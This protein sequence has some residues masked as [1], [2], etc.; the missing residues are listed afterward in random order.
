MMCL[1]GSPSRAFFDAY[2]EIR[3]QQAG[4]EERQD[5]YKL[6]HVLNHYVMFGRGYRR[7]CLQLL[8]SLLSRKYL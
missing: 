4:F 6:Y 5:L 2:F 1:F 8:N 7:M 3:P